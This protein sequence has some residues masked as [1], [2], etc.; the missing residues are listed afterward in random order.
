KWKQNNLATQEKQIEVI[1]VPFQVGQAKLTGNL[2]KELTEKK[3]FLP[4]QTAVVL[5]DENLL[6]PVL[7]SIPENIEAFNVTMGY[8]LSSTPVFTLL[9]SLILLQKNKRIK[10][11]GTISFYHKH[12]V[13]I[14]H[15]PSIQQVE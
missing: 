14:L 13:N 3:N 4:D 7:Y 8:P 9:E 11:D 12:V 6:F 2:L 5:P 15:H 1:G 10:S